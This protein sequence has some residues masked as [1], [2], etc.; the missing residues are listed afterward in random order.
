[1]ADE[2]WEHIPLEVT[3]MDDMS[4]MS[5]F[6]EGLAAKESIGFANKQDLVEKGYEGIVTFYYVRHAESCANSQRVSISSSLPKSFSENTLIT[7]KGIQE[8]L[9][10]ENF[11]SDSN[12]KFDHIFCSANNRTIMTAILSKRHITHEDR[13]GVLFDQEGPIYVYPYIT[14]KPNS[15]VAEDKVNK[16]L[17]FD[18]LII[19][20]NIIRDWYDQHKDE[21]IFIDI[22]LGEKLFNIF[23]KIF[24]FVK[25]MTIAEIPRYIVHFLILFTHFYKDTMD[26][27]NKTAYI[28]IDTIKFYNEYKNSE[29]IIIIDQLT[30]EYFIYV[31]K[32]L[33]LIKNNDLREMSD[34]KIFSIIQHS[35]NI[36]NEILEIDRII[37]NRANMIKKEFSLDY[38]NRESSSNSDNIEFLEKIP[39][40][41]RISGR[42]NLSSFPELNILVYTHGAF[43]RES[44]IP[45]TAQIHKM[46]NTG[47]YKI[48][49]C[50][51]YDVN[52]N[53]SILPI[54]INCEL[55]YSPYDRYRI[56]D[57]LKVNN[58]NLP[59][60]CVRLN[61]VLNPEAGVIK[62]SL[63]AASGFADSTLKS[64]RNLV[65]TTVKIIGKVSNSLEGKD[66]GNYKIGGKKNKK[67]KIKTKK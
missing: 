10:L 42:R 33:A 29:Y 44:V 25:K 3:D 27:Y 37:T 64:T 61:E 16:P 50:Y 4:N 66:D 41:L 30:I 54:P 26:K 20:V 28:K 49:Y 48:Q 21:F 45:P 7:Y 5:K 8:S 15:W 62:G 46:E 13:D 24:N 1:M 35:L 52:G 58:Y 36:L 9:K 65:D 43:I 34:L 39:I 51:K 32:Y 2:D 19:S 6:T 59:D 31:I 40:D 22:D 60:P 47:I 11:L 55:V 12:I 63:T 57:V 67:Y 23:C 38:Y 17:D 56:R 14:E 53:M 18:N